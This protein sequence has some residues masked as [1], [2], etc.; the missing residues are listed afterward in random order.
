M[1][2]RLLLAAAL[3]AAA[4]P[5]RAAA[6]ER[7]APGALILSPEPGERVPADQ[8]LVA[9]SLPR[10]ADSLAVTVRLGSRD[11]SAEVERSG[12]VVTWRPREPLAPGP[13]R[14]VVAA[15]GGGAP[16]EWT[17]TVAPGP[18]LA[19]PTG[20]QR[21]RPSPARPHGSVVME[22]GGNSVS[23][24]GGAFRRED[25]FAPRMWVNAGGQL[26]PGWRYS[27]R[28]HLSG[29]E[30]ATRQPV[31]RLRADLHIPG[32]S[33]AVG[34]VNPVLHDVILSGRRVRG[35]QLDLRAGFAGLS[36]VAGQTVRAIPGALDPLNPARIERRGTYEQDLLAVRP[37]LRL[38]GFRMGLTVMHARDDVGSIPALRTASAAA[39]SGTFSAIPAPRDNLVAGLDVSLRLARDR[40]VLQ[41]EN[42][43]SLLARDISF[44][45]RTQRELDSIFVA[46]GAD[47]PGLDPASWDRFFILNASL[48]P[49]DPRELTST[50]HQARASVRAG[51]HLFS[52]E[53]RSV[54]MD[55]QTMG[56]PGLQRDWQGLRV[57]DSFSLLDALFVTAGYEQDR[58]NLDGSA[59]A[60]RRGQ[61][62]FA[63]VTWQAPRDLLLTGSLRLATRANGLAAGTPGALDESTLAASGGVLVPVGLLAAFRT[64]VSL[65]GTWVERSDPANPLSA[66]RD[67]YVL[68]GVQGETES[69]GTSFSL[70]AGQNR[71]EFPGLPDG[72]TTFDRLTAYGRRQLT[73][74]WAARFDGG[75]TAA[76][77]PESAGVAGPRYTRAEALGGGE[78]AW[79]PDALLSFTAG[80]V[81]YTDR[82]IPG[83]DTRELVMRIR[84]SRAF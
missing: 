2:M 40:I 25:D 7:P 76:R 5:G 73:E 66:T 23:G 46:A 22:G 59:P 15:R 61:G 51:G 11:V 56:H 29:Y 42:A 13:H 31:N 41:Y 19:G 6:Q 18:R 17:F 65:N 53:W 32:L 67:L 82:R 45:P 60:T 80:V 84:L 4:L 69:R 62:G 50:A 57:R 47:P 27:V 35:G 75:L 54:G 77:S 43:A 39:D 63:S 79:R 38:G 74:R 83:L 48:L 72:S 64:R 70:M 10:T 37:S 36:V 16:V 1:R 24:P 9:V 44:R 49:L 28:G 58:D 78:F 68:A 55:Y 30:T 81:D 26:R 34:D 8:V 14:V 33:L 3:A 21:P 52:A 71:A 12:G 20:V